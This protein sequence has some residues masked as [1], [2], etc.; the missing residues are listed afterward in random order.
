DARVQIVDGASS[1]FRFHPAGENEADH[2]GEDQSANH[3]V[4]DQEHLV[5][6]FEAH[7][8]LRAQTA[9]CA[10][11]RKESLV[12]LESRRSGAPKVTRLMTGTG[13]NSPFGR[14]RFRLER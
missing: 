8:S 9:S 5:I 4:H 6:E 1:I 10:L 7:A 14:I 3:N 13:R 2:A 12:S 11:V